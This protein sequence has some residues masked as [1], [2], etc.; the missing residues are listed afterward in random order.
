MTVISLLRPSAHVG[1][2]SGHYGVEVLLACD[3]LNRMTELGRPESTA[4]A[5]DEHGG[6]A[7][8]FVFMHQ[9]RAE[10]SSP[11]RRSPF[12]QR[13]P[14]SASRVTRRRAQEPCTNAESLRRSELLFHNAG[15]GD[16]PV[17]GH[18]AVRKAEV[19]GRS[20]PRRAF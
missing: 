19:V 6:A 8:Q 15:I 5:R 17:L 1:G 12:V 2:V 16:A 20:A 10:S 3:V 7:S 4:S 9:R 14:D 11:R 13:Q 18:F